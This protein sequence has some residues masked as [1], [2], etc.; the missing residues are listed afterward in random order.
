MTDII[1]TGACGRMGKVVSALC[2]ESTDLR[3]VA[4]VDI[5]SA[6]G[7]LGF[8]YPV[9][10]KLDDFEGDADVIVDFS[11]HS[12]I[13]AIAKYA[14]EKKVAL[15]AATTGYNEEELAILKCL[16][17]KV[18]VFYSRNMSL[19]INLLIELTKKATAVLGKKFDIEIVE[20]HHNKK[21]DAPSGTALMLA[22]AAAETMGSEPEYVYD[23]QSV[24]RS[25]S[26]NEIG[27]HSV[28]GGS[29][30]GDH[31][32]AFCG[33]D[34]VISLSHSAYSRNVFAEGAVSAAAFIKG[35]PAG[36]YDMSD[37]ISS[38]L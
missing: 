11:H 3:I 21:L 28:R 33:Q 9:Y 12:A 7:S 1:L 4:G 16:S 22:D 31:E 19:G 37:L 30:V 26:D 38:A 36:M 14:T 17:E 34:E 2:A 20:R 10:E 32:V 27:I 8:P 29:I 15:V 6:S 35:K 13:Y 24:R 18:P 5:N 25:R 23:R